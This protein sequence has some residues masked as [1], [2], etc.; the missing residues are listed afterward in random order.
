M[1]F[2]EDETILTG[3]VNEDSIIDGR[4]ATVTLTEYAR[5]SVGYSPTFSARQTKAADF[6]KDSVI[7]ARDAS[8]I[9]VYYAETS[10]A[11]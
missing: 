8:A 7:D 11:K 5:I 3:D 6:N 9:L 1:V 4:D 10:V 2:S